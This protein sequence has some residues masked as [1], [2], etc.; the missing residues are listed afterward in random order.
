MKNT[1]KYVLIFAKDENGNEIPYRFMLSINK[2]IKAVE[3][4]LLEALMGTE[5]VDRM[6][7]HGRYTAEVVIGRAF[8]AEE[9]LA[10]LRT[11]LDSVLSDIITPKLVL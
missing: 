7:I 1:Q 2:S 5:G 10:E 11:K 4:S 6:E 8:D 9:V 3:K